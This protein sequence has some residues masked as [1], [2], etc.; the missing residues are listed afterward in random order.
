M[1]KAAVKLLCV[2]LLL[3]I[4]SATCISIQDVPGTGVLG[5]TPGTP[6]PKPGPSAPDGGAPFPCIPDSPCPH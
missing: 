5:G 2:C 3:F 6:L 1:K 4:G